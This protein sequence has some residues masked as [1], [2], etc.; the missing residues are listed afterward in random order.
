MIGKC[1]LKVACIAVSLLNF[2]KY[3]LSF[4]GILKFHFTPHTVCSS[5]I[6]GN[7]TTHNVEGDVLNLERTADDELVF[8]GK[9]MISEAD[10]M[11]TNGVIHLLDDIIIP[12]S[13]IEL[14]PT[15][16]SYCFNYFNISRT[17]Y[18]KCAEEPQL[19]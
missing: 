2:K 10:I 4:S 16:S 9:A 6:I 8:E 5:A 15:L 17:I 13:G 14:N 18:R 3:A 19:Q 11:G 1:S 7:A 12:P